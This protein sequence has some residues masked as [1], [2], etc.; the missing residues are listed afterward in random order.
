M[1]THSKFHYTTSFNVPGVI[2]N[3]KFFWGKY[4]ITKWKNPY[5]T[6][7]Q[8]NYSDPV[9]NENQCNKLHTCAKGDI[10]GLMPPS[11]SI[12]ATVHAIL[13]SLATKKKK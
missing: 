4:Q 10:R 1:M 13:S 12:C 9:E 2:K 8:N 11:R 7:K 3:N 5:Q 6:E